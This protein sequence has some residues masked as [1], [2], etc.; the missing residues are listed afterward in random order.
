MEKVTKP[1]LPWPLPARLN[2][3]EAAEYLGFKPHGIPVLVRERLLRPLGH[4]RHSAVKYF[5]TVAL[6][7]LRAD[8]NWLSRATDAVYEHCRDKNAR[9][10]A[11]GACKLRR[12][13]SGLDTYS[14]TG[15]EDPRPGDEPGA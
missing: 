3:E 4:P 13:N 14:T 1:N 15:G 7:Q 2:P 5:A 8:A 10:T 12:K 9:K 11:K 6:E